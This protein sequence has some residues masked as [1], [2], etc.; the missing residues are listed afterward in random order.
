M[1]IIGKHLK[2]A[3]DKSQTLLA[4]LKG[5]EDEKQKILQEILRM[6]GVVRELTLIRDEWDQEKKQGKKNDSSSK[7][8]S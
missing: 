7:K 8:S 3:Q 2:D 6:D 5:N 1:N 4:E